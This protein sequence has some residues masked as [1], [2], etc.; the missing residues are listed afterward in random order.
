MLKTSNFID[1]P[2]VYLLVLFYLKYDYNLAGMKEQRVAVIGLGY[3]GLPLALLAEEKGYRVVGIDASP[4]KIVKLKEGDPQIDDQDA[5]RRLKKSKIDFSD[6]FS[7][8][9]TADIAIVCVP[10]P[11]KENKLPDLSIVKKATLQ[12]VQQLKNGALLIIESTINPGVCDEVLTP[13]IERETQHK[14]GQT[15]H[16]AHC[17]E[18]INP[19]DPKYHV[20]NINRVVGADSDKSLTMTYDFYSS[21][22]DAKI[23]K[24]ATIKEAEAVKIVENSFRDIN[25]AFVNELAMS[26]AKLG[27]NVV[28]VINGAATKP[29][30]FMPHFPGIGVGGHCIPVDPYYL[31]EY[32]HNNGFEHK[33]LS[34][35]RAINENMPVFCVDSVEQELIKAGAASLEGKKVCVLGLSYKANVGDIRESPS[36]KVIKVLKERGC[37]VTTF[38]PY[39]VEKST[40]K[41]LAEAM[42]NQDVVMLVTAHQ[43]FVDEALNHLDSTTKVF[44]DGRNA[45]I[46]RR[47]D[48]EDKNI[49]Y[50]GV[51]A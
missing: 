24:M 5:A 17:P 38:D 45:F 23:K 48:F 27:I 1:T 11:V 13:M 22:V 10:T 39:F 21:I 2:S 14:V 43:E 49:A 46:D 4:Q 40:A 32:A 7:K 34:L 28:N 15:I 26:F 50:I 31:I 33:F 30:A 41:S 3:V 29:F 51:G 6:D 37:E 20:G 25:I 36:L 12:T 42:A 16:L 8:V 35:A 19:G 9:K 44:L 47:Q 18:R